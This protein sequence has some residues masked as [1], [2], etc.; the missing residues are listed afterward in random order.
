MQ[1]VSW[2]MDKPVNTSYVTLGHEL[3]L[4]LRP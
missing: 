3:I 2:Y 1:Q 4:S